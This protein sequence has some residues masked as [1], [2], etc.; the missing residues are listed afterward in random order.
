MNRFSDKV[1]EELKHY[2]YLLFDPRD[3]EIFYVGKGEN[4]RVFQHELEKEEK[5]KNIRI[6]DIVDSGHDVKKVILRYGLSDDTAKEVESA[7]IDFCNYSKR[8]DLTNLI[9]AYHSQTPM[10]VEDI[11]TDLGAIKLYADDIKDNLIVIKINQLYHNGMTTDEI[12]DCARGHWRIDSKR[13]LKADYLLAVYHGRIVGVFKDMEWHPSSEE[14]DDYPRLSE[15]N[16][17]LKGRKYCT[18]VEVKDSE[19]LGKDI[20]PIVENSQYP[21]RYINRST[22]KL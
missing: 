21:V 15:S 13:A 22:S 17:K 4:D 6:K 11:E 2:V 5:E 1:K 10:A 19:Y 3:D 14:S 12:K 18:C 9:S 20:S 7:I 16:L 8:I